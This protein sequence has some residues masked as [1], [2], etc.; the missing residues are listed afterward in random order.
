MNTVKWLDW[1][2]LKSYVSIG[3]INLRYFE[4]TRKYEIHAADSFF[5]LAANVFK[6]GGP[7][8]TD[9][10]TNFK[11]TSN[12]PVSPVMTTQYEMNDKDLKLARGMIE[13][14][15]DTTASLSLKIPGTF[16]TTDGRYVAG[17]YAIGE[18]YDIDDYI[19]VYVEDTERLIALA[20]AQSQD[21][22][23]TVPIPDAEMQALGVIPM[24]GEA[25]PAY[26]IVKSYTDD[27]LEAANQ[28]WYFWP[29][30]L[31]NNDPAAS[32]CEIDPIGGYGFI[33][34]GLY[35][36]VHYCRATKTTGGIRVNFWWG[37]KE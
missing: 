11:S 16:G 7:D 37:K 12:Q 34:A 24:L 1:T 32:E 21:P 35:V 2:T 6:N 14:N 27:D 10:E 33:P 3:N 28:G 22:S 17:G 23:A 25:V 13:L 15:G 8:Q 31:G 5:H 36:I 19:T 20:V 18:D 30:A 9:F 4:D 26:P 29:V